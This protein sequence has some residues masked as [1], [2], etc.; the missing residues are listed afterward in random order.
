[1]HDRRV[2]AVVD[3][4]GVSGPRRA[5]Q[6]AEGLT[7][8]A[9]WLRVGGDRATLATGL[10]DELARG[11]I[12]FHSTSRRHR[13]NRIDPELRGALLELQPPTVPDET[14]APQLPRSFRPSLVAELVRST[15]VG[16]AH[17]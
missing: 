11:R 12:E 17:G 9:L 3:G 15:D 10:R 7:F 4:E 14:D 8:H 13:M 2:R 16:G 5:R 6:A 1:M